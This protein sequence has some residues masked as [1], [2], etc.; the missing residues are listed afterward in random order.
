MPNDKVK[1]EAP[2]PDQSVK[3]WF[4]SYIASP[5]YKERLSAFYKYPEY[6]QKKR[7]ER[8]AALSITKEAGGDI[9]QYDTDSN[10]VRASAAGLLNAKAAEDEVFAH[11]Y[12]HAVNSPDNPAVAS[13]SPRE[14]AFIFDRNIRDPELKKDKKAEAMRLGMG[15][16]YYLKSSPSLRDLKPSESHSDINA[17]RYLL[18]K[19][20]IYDAGTQN[21]TPE[22]LQKA[23]KD[24]VIR[25]SFIYKRLKENFEDQGLLE[26]MNKVASTNNKQSNIA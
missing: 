24:P 15:L 9:L 23:A 18:N 10:S 16:S 6:M 12:G 8:A 13:L 2:K 25:K 3:D 22:I 20:G 1:K 21:F 26:I 5:K 17:F 4:Q 14:E 11:E 19:R 7:E